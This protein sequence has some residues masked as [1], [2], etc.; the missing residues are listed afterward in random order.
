[1]RSV[2][3]CIVRM[4]KSRKMRWVVHVARMRTVYNILVG[5][6]EGKRTRKTEMDLEETGLQSVD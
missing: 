2:I 1:M 5:K 3:I 4:I 6:P